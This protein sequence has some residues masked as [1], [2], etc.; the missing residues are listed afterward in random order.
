M[1]GD[2]GPRALRSPGVLAGRLKRAIVEN[3]KRPSGV[4]NYRPRLFQTP[5]G[6]EW[7]FFCR[8]KESPGPH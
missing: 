4:A 3:R 7:P 2:G 5:A 8:R 6:F 1:L